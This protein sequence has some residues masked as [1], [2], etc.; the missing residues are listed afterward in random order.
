MF[1]D[2]ILEKPPSTNGENGKYAASDKGLHHSAD[3]SISIFF[4]Y[5]NNNNNNNKAFKSQTS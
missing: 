1:S 2:I 3:V 5:N 4:F